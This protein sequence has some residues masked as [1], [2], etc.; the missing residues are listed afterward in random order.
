MPALVAYRCDACGYSLPGGFG[1]VLYAVDAEGRRVV[2]PHPGEYPTAAAVLGVPLSE[3]QEA[4]LDAKPRWWWAPGRR[5]KHEVVAEMARTRIGYVVELACLDCDAVTEIDL[6]RD[7]RVCSK[8]GGSRI[9]ASGE[10]VDE[11]CPRC[12]DGV[13][14]ARNTGIMS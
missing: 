4:L 2:C 7:R 14:R 13:I 1:P 5:R 3:L 10:L 9:H 11:A 8:C 12:H 6:K